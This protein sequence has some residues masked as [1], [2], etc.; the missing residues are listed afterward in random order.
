KEVAWKLK[1]QH[2]QELE[3]QIDMWDKELTPWK[4]FILPSGHASYSALHTARTVVRRAERTAVGLGEQVNPL[5]VP[6]LYRLSYLLFVV[7]RYVNHQLNGTEIP[8]QADV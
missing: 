4:N 6:Y 2:I 1:Q 8:L 3:D 5:V 7:A